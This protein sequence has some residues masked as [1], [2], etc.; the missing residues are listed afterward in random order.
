MVVVR[1]PLPPRSI[2]TVIFSF[3]EVC[4]KMTQK[5]WVRHR[6]DFYNK[7]LWRSTSFSVSSLQIWINMSLACCHFFLTKNQPGDIYFWYEK[8][9]WN[10]RT[11]FEWF[12]LKY[13]TFKFQKTFDSCFCDRIVLFY[14]RSPCLATAYSI[15]PCL[16]IYK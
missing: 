15:S 5:F 14:V 6:N 10:K 13:F 16:R 3:T 7:T 4:G 8:K 11:F 12:V 1:P 2:F 9:V